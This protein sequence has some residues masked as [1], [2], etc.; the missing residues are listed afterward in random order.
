MI[1]SNLIGVENISLEDLRNVV[2]N[3]KDSFSSD[4]YITWF[5]SQL[6]ESNNS[7]I[8]RMLEL[9][10]KHPT[11][12]SS[13]FNTIPDNYILEKILKNELSRGTFDKYETSQIP[14][15]IQNKEFRRIAHYFSHSLVFED[16]TSA[17][18]T[19]NKGLFLYDRGFNLV[20][21]L[22][23]YSLRDEKSFFSYSSNLGLILG[24]KIE[25]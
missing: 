14:F 21:E 1:V 23:G 8:K 13:G 10:K 22:E 5:E 12:F 20:S 16:G 15:S 3:Q 6:E 25:H 4:H 2:K 9:S 17:D 7:I 24:S 18:K 19:K 11:I